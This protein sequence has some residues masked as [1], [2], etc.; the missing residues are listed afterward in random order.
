MY[1]ILPNLA[2]EQIELNKAGFSWWVL[3]VCGKRDY[4][5]LSQLTKIISEGAKFIILP[6]PHFHK[7]FSADYNSIQK[8]VF[9]KTPLKVDTLAI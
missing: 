4:H 6:P 2:T 1:D 8:L 3:T 7:L 5:C 9:P